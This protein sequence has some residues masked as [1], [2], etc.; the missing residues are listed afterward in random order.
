MITAT[1]TVARSRS[2]KTL[3]M[4]ALTV[5]VMLSGCSDTSKVAE[6]SAD[7]AS[8]PAATPPPTEE[9]LLLQPPPAW[10]RI[11]E[12]ASEAFRLAEY[13]PAGQDKDSWNDRL[14]I[15]ANALKP[16]P[17]PISFLEAMGAELKTECTGSSHNNVHSGFENG[18][19]TSVRLLICNKNNVSA[20]SEVSIIKAIQGED[21][22]YVISRARRSDALQNNAPPLTKKEMGEWT[23]Y[24]RSIKVCDPRSQNHPCPVSADE[25]T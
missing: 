2:T 24:M 15:E 6:Q 21:F 1:P 16:L 14:F 10:L 5:L 22:F 3:S 7:S 18:Y 17:D 19:P 11:E 20:R 25:Q 13:V 12:Q 4:L 23:L 9:T 8:Q